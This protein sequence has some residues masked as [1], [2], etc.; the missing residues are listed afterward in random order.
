V[1]DYAMF[2]GW[3]FCGIFQGWVIGRIAL[4]NRN[5]KLSRVSRRLPRQ[6]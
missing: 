2:A 1:P 3:A 5:R 4:F 6:A